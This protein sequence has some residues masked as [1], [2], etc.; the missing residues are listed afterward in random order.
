MVAHNCHGK[1]QF[2]T[3]KQ[4]SKQQI[5]IT[6]VKLPTFTAKATR[7]Y[8][9]ERN[10]VSFLERYSKS[11]KGQGFDIFCMRSPGVRG[12]CANAPLST[13]LI[14]SVARAWGFLSR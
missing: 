5:Q 4:N 10:G 6:P 3:A 13:A 14:C 11:A 1:V 12:I 8:F 9:S 2:I 7:S